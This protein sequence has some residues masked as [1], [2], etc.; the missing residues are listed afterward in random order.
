MQTRTTLLLWISPEV[1]V[2]FSTLNRKEKM[3]QKPSPSVQWLNALVFNLPTASVR[4]CF[5]VHIEVTNLKGLWDQ[6]GGVVAGAP[7][8]RVVLTDHSRVEMCVCE[9]ICVCVRERWG[10]GH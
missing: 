3:V 7:G 4:H 5:M 6:A 1:P 8:D 10:M 9:C 2:V